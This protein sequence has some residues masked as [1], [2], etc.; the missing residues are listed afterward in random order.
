MSQYSLCPQTRC[1]RYDAWH[2]KLAGRGGDTLPRPTTRER[3]VPSPGRVPPHTRHHATARCTARAA[4]A[5]VRGADFQHKS[6][7]TKRYKLPFYHPH[8]AEENCQSNSTTPPTAACPTPASTTPASSKALWI[9][10]RMRSAAG[11]PHTLLWTSCQCRA[12]HSFEQ[13]HACRHRSHLR[14]ALRGAPS[15]PTHLSGLAASLPSALAI[16]P[17]KRSW[18]LLANTALGWGFVW[19]ATLTAPAGG[20]GAVR[21]P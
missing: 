20:S 18:S 2:F 1:T 5:V 4:H 17:R 12:W 21:S 14:H 11:G 15:Q 16:R 13:Y 10:L 6:A 7:E 3:R 19:A 8:R 9:L